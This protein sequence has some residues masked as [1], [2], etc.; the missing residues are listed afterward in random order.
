MQLA[1]SN[2]Q[3]VC[4]QNCLNKYGNDGKAA[5][6]MQ[7]GLANSPNMGAQNRDCGAI[8]K[9]CMRGCGKDKACKSRCRD[10]RRS[11]I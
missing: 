11:C 1:A 8:Y 4:F 3:G 9:T 6:A 2:Q 10:A 5:C 7:C